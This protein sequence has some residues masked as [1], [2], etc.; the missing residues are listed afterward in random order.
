MAG[1][2]GLFAGLSVEESNGGAFVNTVMAEG[3]TIGPICAGLAEK[4]CIAVLKIFAIKN[5]IK[6][7]HRVCLDISQSHQKKD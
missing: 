4:V 5:K 1:L 2:E 3:R 7:S 6:Y